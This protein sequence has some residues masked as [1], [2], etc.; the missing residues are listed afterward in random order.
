M[1]LIALAG[2]CLA[3]TLPTLSSIQVHA[4]R[5]VAYTTVTVRAGDSLWTLAEDRTASGGDVQATLD[6]IVVANHLSST[7]LHPGQRLLLP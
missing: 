6:A 2:L 3:V 5:P 7:A 4:A 1:P